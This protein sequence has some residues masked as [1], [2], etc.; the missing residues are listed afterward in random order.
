MKE[1]EVEAAKVDGF[2]QTLLLFSITISVNFEVK[3]G[4]FFTKHYYDSRYWKIGMIIDTVR[5]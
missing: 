3:M 5:V 1:S 4:H 2:H